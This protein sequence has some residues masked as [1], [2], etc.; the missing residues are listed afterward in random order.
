MLSPLTRT[1]LP[2]ATRLPRS[3]HVAI[4]QR[5]FAELEPW[6]TRFRIAGEEF[7]GEH[8]LGE[9]ARLDQFWDAL[10]QAKRI[11][12]LGSLEGGHSFAFAERGAT[13]VAV[14][15]RADNV[16]RAQAVQKLLG[17]R[18]VRFVAADLE[19]SPLSSFGS[20][21]AIFC[22]GL[23]YHLPRPWTLVDTMRSAA[24]AV[25]MWT[26]YCA[27]DAVDA[28][29]DGAPGCW[30]QEYGHAD[31]LSGL[32]ERSFWP[33]LPAL[34]ERLET[35]GFPNVR[36]IEDDPGHLHK[37]AVTLVAEA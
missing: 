6:V 7:G 29:V 30:Y 2:L 32:S 17:I 33:T 4:A 1:L 5:A 31:P 22:V 8:L 28:E 24:P 16:A 20:F 18:G 15:G 27:E 23:L 37:G 26:H 19:Q 21:D 14:E 25:F 3:R 36:I 13:V 10:P 12:E 35:Q 9:D 34:V 11:L